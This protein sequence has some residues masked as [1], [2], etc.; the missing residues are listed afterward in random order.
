MD[1]SPS[2]P[3]SL[4]RARGRPPLARRLESSNRKAAEEV[5]NAEMNLLT[6]LFLPAVLARRSIIYL[7]SFSSFSPFFKKPLY[8]WVKI[9][10]LRSG[11]R[12]W[13]SL[14]ESGEER[15]E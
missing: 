15:E 10:N 13:R 6:F 9:V 11:S 3:P 12:D 8:C 1:F 4:W 7:S 14:E 5:K 2:L